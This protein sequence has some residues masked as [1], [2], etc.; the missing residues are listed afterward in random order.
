METLRRY[1]TE[2]RLG[3]S[4]KMLAVLGFICDLEITLPVIER[5]IVSHE[6]DLLA[7]VGDSDKLILIGG[8]EEMRLN[9]KK[10]CDLLKI[11]DLEH[12]EILMA[13]EV[14]L[15]RSEGAAKDQLFAGSCLRGCGMWSYKEKPSRIM[16]WFCP[17]AHFKII[18]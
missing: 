12:Q 15:S 7:D 5:L 14:L 9:L 16:A 6:G 10:V 8:A 3:A 17:R 4:P 11:P 2:G 1:L 13:L 18:L